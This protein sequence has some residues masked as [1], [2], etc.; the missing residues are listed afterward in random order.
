MHCSSIISPNPS[1]QRLVWGERFGHGRMSYI[2]ANG[3]SEAGSISYEGGSE[4]VY[5]PLMT[6]PG[7]SSPPSRVP[8]VLPAAP[9]PAPAP[10]SDPSATLSPAG[11]HQSLSSLPVPDFPAATYHNGPPHYGP[12]M[13]LLQHPHPSFPCLYVQDALFLPHE[14]MIP[15]NQALGHQPSISPHGSVGDASPATSWGNS[16]AVGHTQYFPAASSSYSPIYSAYSPGALSTSSALSH[17]TQDD[18]Y[19][20]AQLTYAEPQPQPGPAMGHQ[21]GLLLQDSDQIVYPRA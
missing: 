16:P 12:V 10:A 13:C 8:V 6:F 9:T 4:G 11:L 14:G 15:Q 17:S 20:P 7:S 5:T 21:G 2:T 19:V 18:F 3:P 1:S